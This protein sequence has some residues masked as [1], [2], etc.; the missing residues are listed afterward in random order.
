MLLLKEL[1]SKKSKWTYLIIGVGLG[2]CLFLIFS[3]PKILVG[4]LAFLGLGAKTQKEQLKEILT[5]RQDHQQEVAEIEKQAETNKE[6]ARNSREQEAKD[7][8]D[9]DF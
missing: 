4:L 2:L 7:W 1:L 6:T 5:E 9:G 8:L 3:A